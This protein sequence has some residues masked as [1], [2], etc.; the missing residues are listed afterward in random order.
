MKPLLVFTMCLALLTLSCQDSTAPSSE[1]G[2]AQAVAI[3]DSGKLLVRV[4]FGD[5]GVPDKRV[6][7]VELG[8]VRKT[9]HAGYALFVLPA[10][11]YTLRA[12][13]I[14]RGG[15]SLLHYDTPVKIRANVKTRVEIFDC[16]PCV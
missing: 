15:P 6:E 3:Y 14:N 1:T 4:Y 11:A 2:S 8:I 10:G 9:N 13:E 12:Y 5:E 7:I 16:L